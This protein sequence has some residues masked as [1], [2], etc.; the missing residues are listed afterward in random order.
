MVIEAYACSVAFK[1]FNRRRGRRGIFEAVT[2]SKDP[3]VFT[4][5][6]E[7]AAAMLGLVVAF[8]GIL[9]GQILGIPELDGAAS[10]VIAA[11]LAGAAIFLAYETKGLLIGEAADQDLINAIRRRLGSDSSVRRVNELLTVHQGPE[12]VLLNVSV[13]FEDGISSE[14]VEAA[15]SS[16]ERRIK[17]QH[18]EIKRLFIEVQSWRGHEAAKNRD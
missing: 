16:L 5:L 15:I 11:I 12:D 10:I 13:D 14:Q 6:F 9:L 1:E 17:T 7:D 2:I 8:V 18:P 3:S 4:V